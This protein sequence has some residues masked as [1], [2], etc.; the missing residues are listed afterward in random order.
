MRVIAGTA[1]GRKLKAPPGSPTRPVT[2]RIKEALFNVI[3]HDIPGASFLDLFAGSGSVGIEALSRGAAR[4]IFIDNHP[5]AVAVIRENL[6]HCGFQS[7]FEVYRNDVFKAIPILNKRKLVFDYIYVD[8]PFT[9]HQLFP[10]VIQ[11]IDDIPVLSAGGVMI[12]RVPRGEPLPD[13][14]KLESFRS[15]SY[16]ESTLVY[17]QHR[18]RGIDQDGTVRD[19]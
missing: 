1:K 12:I 9:Q 10:A 5:A 16:G 8:P 18:N 13:L 7:G 6:K 19:T 17:Y 4:V 11:V 3:G 2:D 14:R 15:D